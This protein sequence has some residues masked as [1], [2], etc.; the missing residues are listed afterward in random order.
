NK[1]IYEKISKSDPFALLER[2]PKI[3]NEPYADNVITAIAP[4]S[5][6]TI[7]TYAQSTSNLSGLVRRN[8][9]PLVKTIVAIAD[10]SKNTLKVLPFLGLIARGEKT[11][12]EIDAIANNNDKYLQAL[13][14]LIVADE[15]MGRKDIETELNRRC[16]WYI[17]EINRLHDSPDN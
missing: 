4:L 5:P 7:L 2:L 9:D 1:I 3:V 10:Q 8:N 14:D 11:I 15:Q 16:M 12:K 17:N 6:S 13:V